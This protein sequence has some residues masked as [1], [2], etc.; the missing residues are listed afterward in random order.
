[1]T[2]LLALLLLATQPAPFCEAEAWEEKRLGDL[3]KATPEED[4][5]RLR[6]L[7]EKWDRAVAATDACIIS[8][9]GIPPQD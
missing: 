2:I 1:M 3:I 9:G 6:D 7:F 5:E 8:H 4:L